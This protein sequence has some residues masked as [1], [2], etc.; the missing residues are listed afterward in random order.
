MTDNTFFVLRRVC[1]Y[2]FMCIGAVVTFLKSLNNNGGNVLFFW[3]PISIQLG[4]FLA[5]GLQECLSLLSWRRIRGLLL[6]LLDGLRLF[7]G[8]EEMQ[9]PI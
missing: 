6:S 4:I 8:A 2:H 1:I 9:L 3:T 5:V 7:M